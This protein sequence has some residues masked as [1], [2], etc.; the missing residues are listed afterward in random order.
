MPDF[1]D[2]TD[3]EFT[4]GDV[5]F[6]VQKL[7]PEP[8]YELLESILYELSEPAKAVGSA[9]PTAGALLSAVL[10]LEPGFKKRVRDVLFRHVTFQSNRAR[11]PQPLVGSAGSAVDMAFADLP[12]VA[13]HDVMMR[14]L[15]VNFTGSWEYLD[16]KLGLK[17]LASNFANLAEQH[18]SAVSSGL[19]STPESPP[20]PSAG[21]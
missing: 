3:P 6:A 13:I 11:T 8:A 5:H 19:S 1:A 21:A 9:E 4:I 14:A 12:A 2:W 20:T 7:P 15:A 16:S 18:G 10:S 17:N